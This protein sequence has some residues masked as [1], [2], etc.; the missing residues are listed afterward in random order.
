MIG[1]INTHLGNINAI[2]NIYTELGVDVIK[3][4]MPDQLDNVQKIIVPG[5][6]SFDTVINHLKKTKIYE[7]ISELVLNQ[8]MPILGICIGMQIFYERSDE[9][10][11]NGLGWVKGNINKMEKKN[12]KY[13]HMGWNKIKIR[14]KSP[15]FEGIINDD[16]FYFLH[17]F[18][19]KFT[20]IND[21]IVTT[22]N[23]GEEFISSINI[24]N[25]YGVQFHPEKSHESGIKLLSNFANYC[26]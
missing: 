19:N 23:Y 2:K 13:P 25:I 6:G 9:G 4:D 16:Y 5:I 22:S 18:S 20:E 12:I 21:H 15:L 14:N 26:D 3:I 10:T 11:L 17:S 7:K 1:I 8:N 24:D